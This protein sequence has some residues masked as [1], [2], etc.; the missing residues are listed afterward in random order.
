M[1]HRGG[2]VEP[3]LFGNNPAP[4]SNKVNYDEWS[5]EFSVVL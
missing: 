2:V 4:R 5:A 3:L 1:A